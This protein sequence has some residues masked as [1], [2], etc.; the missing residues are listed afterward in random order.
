MLARVRR[1]EAVRAPTSPFVRDYGSFDAF[2]A[3]VEGEIA[4]GALDVDVR[5]VVHCLAKWDRDGLLAAGR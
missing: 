5:V 3:W 2:A 1:L 4:A